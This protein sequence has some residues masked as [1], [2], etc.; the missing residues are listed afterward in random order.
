MGRGVTLFRCALGASVAGLLG[1]CGADAQDSTVFEEA[2]FVIAPGEE[3]GLE[4]EVAR[5]RAAQ[6][7]A[8]ACMR[9]QGWPYV[10]WSGFELVAESA[11][12]APPLGTSEF[13]AERGY[14]L[15]IGFPES[16]LTHPSA[17]QDPNQ[18]FF[19]G[20]SD[21][22][23]FAYSQTRLGADG[24]DGVRRA[25]VDED[26]YDEG[27]C[28]G[29]ELRRDGGYQRGSLLGSLFGPYQQLQDQV[30]ADARLLAYDEEWSRCMAESGFRYES[31]PDARDEFQMRYDELW[32]S[33]FFP[34]TAVPSDDVAA[35][36]ESERAELYALQPEYDREQWRRWLDAEIEV[37]V[38][39]LACQG[40]DARYDTFSE[41]LAEFEDQF[42]A[43]NQVVFDELDAVS[44]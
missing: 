42:I 5:Q 23:K 4:V 3:F 28:L 44:G 16:I 31:S 20:L 12:S 13:A 36:S 39:D 33:V 40:D 8:A 1:A 19:D 2:G 34:A 26:L 37:A 25:S 17:K 9:E 15:L 35:M 38:A 30:N 6:E 7:A 29:R 21:E 27:G 24:G 10:P 43:D 41:V 32:A 18:V 22:E 14:G 11:F